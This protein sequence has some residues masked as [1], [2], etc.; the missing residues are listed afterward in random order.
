ML[1]I[2][3]FK[4]RHIMTERQT[5]SVGSTYCKLVET[6]VLFLYIN[7]SVSLHL[8]LLFVQFEMTVSDSFSSCLHF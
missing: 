2:Q 8:K 4:S 5:F 1:C 6:R 7:V 3:N